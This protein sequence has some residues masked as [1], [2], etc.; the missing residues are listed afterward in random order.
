MHSFP[1]FIKE[2]N[3]LFGFISHTKIANLAKKE[4]KRTQRSFFNIYLYIYLYI[5][6]YIYIYILKKERDVL[7][8]FAI[9]R[10][11]LTFFY[12]LCQRMLRSLQKNLVF[13]AFFYGLCKRMLHSLRS[14]TFFAKEHCV[15]C[16][17]FCSLEKNR[18]ERSFGSHKSPK[19]QKNNGK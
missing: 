15:L 4:C 16:A 9:E 19:T 17:L 5:S 13:F 8:F 6:T 10:N 3:I 18:K 14:F 11:V 2:R 1:F 7:R 12:V